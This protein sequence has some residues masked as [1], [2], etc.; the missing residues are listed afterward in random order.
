MNTQQRYERNLGRT[1][2]DSNAATTPSV[3]RSHLGIHGDP[4]VTQVGRQPGRPGRPGLAWVRMTELPSYLGSPV[5]RRGI[6][7][8]TELAHRA[9]HAP[10]S[11][12][13]RTRAKLRHSSP[14]TDRHSVEATGRGLDD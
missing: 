1:L 5:A 13:T 9:R 3:E 7:L 12:A 14:E 4:S 2:D 6:D 8:Q 11:V 10:L